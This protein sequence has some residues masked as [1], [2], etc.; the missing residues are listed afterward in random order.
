[1]RYIKMPSD[2]KARKFSANYGTAE[3]VPFLET[4]FSRRLFKGILIKLRRWDSSSII[5]TT[6]C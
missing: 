6:S 3:A 5:S 1:M 4:E 2:A